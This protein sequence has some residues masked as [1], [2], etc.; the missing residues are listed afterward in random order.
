LT[1]REEIHREK[2]NRKTEKQ[3]N[4]KTEKQK[5]RKTDLTPASLLMGRFVLTDN[6][7][8]ANQLVAIQ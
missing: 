8:F 7:W 6:S 3:K 1:Q 5:N 2:K 4:R